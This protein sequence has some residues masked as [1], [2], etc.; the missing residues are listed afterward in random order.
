MRR[1]VAALRRHPAPDALYL[2]Y[3]DLRVMPSFP[4]V[5]AVGGL[6]WSA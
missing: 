2:D 6:K 5:S 1:D 4:G 3:A